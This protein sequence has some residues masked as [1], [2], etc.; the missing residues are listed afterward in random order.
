MDGRYYFGPMRL[1]MG[2]VKQM[3]ASLI[4][5]VI[6]QAVFGCGSEETL[7][8]STSE[9]HMQGRRAQMEDSSRFVLDE[10]SGTVTA[11]LGDGHGG[12]QIAHLL[13]EA[14]G[15][16]FLGLDHVPTSQDHVVFIKTVDFIA[17]QMPPHPCLVTG[18]PTEPGSTVNVVSLSPDGTLVSTNYGDSFALTVN[19]KTKAVT[20]LTKEFS[21]L[22]PGEMA[23][24]QALPAFERGDV[25]IHWSG[26]SG[27]SY[28]AAGC[29]KINTSGLGHPAHKKTGAM[30][31]VPHIT[32]TKIGPDD[33]VLVGCDGMV[34]KFSYQDVGA[35]FLMWLNAVGGDHE[36]AVRAT[37]ETVYSGGGDPNMVSFDNISLMCMGLS[38]PK[39][40]AIKTDEPTGLA[41]D[42]KDLS[43]RVLSSFNDAQFS[44]V[45]EGLAMLRGEVPT[46]S[47][48]E[49]DL[50]V[51]KRH[52]GST[53][54]ESLSLLKM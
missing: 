10:K 40:E 27:S 13:A 45:Q 15:P 18:R 1:A 24:I 49:P 5:A 51:P 53:M 7:Q 26:S 35:M 41:T 22:M 17:C 12:H 36:A 20:V 32:E 31:M 9:F 48:R 42:H 11:V 54:Q 44:V 46:K 28:L 52:Q 3:V 43:S 6:R 8:I 37:V 33:L 4:D 14:A 25:W 23:R 47:L 21:H 50:F 2:D 34:E 38:S 29:S 16:Y 39:A 19:T 30:L